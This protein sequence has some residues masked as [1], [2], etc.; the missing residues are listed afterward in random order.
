VTLLAAGCGSGGALVPAAGK[1]TINEAPLRNA[2]VQ[3][4]PIG[5]TPGNQRGAG[6]TNEDGEFTLTNR[7][8]KP[9]LE[10]GTYKVVVSKM[11]LPDGSDYEPKA[12]VA[13]MDSPARERLPAKYSDPEKTEL[14]ETIT[15]ENKPLE[16]SLTVTGWK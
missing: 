5:D 13:P 15:T 14:K 9:G 11:V 16:I 10:P 1:V 8:G 12:G 6:R 4:I 2:S 3:F 7:Q